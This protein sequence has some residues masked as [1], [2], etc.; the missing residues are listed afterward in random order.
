[1]NTKLITM[2][3]LSA[4]AIAI[5]SCVAKKEENKADES[6]GGASNWEE[7][8]A[9]HL[10]M[11]ETFHPFKD[12]ANLEPVKKA[13]VALAAA[14]DRWIAAP[15]PAKVDNEEV[16]SNLQKLKSEATALREIVTTEDDAAIAARLT[17]LHDTF[18]QIQEAWYAK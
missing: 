2:V 4:F 9:F 10:I 17:E 5:F 16:K 14:A 1:M 13:A 15:L 3:A 12:S 11:A 7:M 6:S 8:D 18:H